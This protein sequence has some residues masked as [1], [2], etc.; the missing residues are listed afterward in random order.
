MLKTSLVD[1]MRQKCSE[2]TLQS[3]PK[4]HFGTFVKM[5]MEANPGCLKTFRE[6]DTDEER[7]MFCSLLNNVN[8]MVVKPVYKQKNA[9]L[10]NKKRSEGNE[11][12][13][14]KRYKQAAMLYTVSVMKAEAGQ[15][16]LAYSVANRSAC[17]YYLGDPAR[18]LADTDLALSL[19]YPDQ[20]RCSTQTGCTALPCS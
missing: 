20:V 14:A 17:L 2:V 7:V 11:A 9:E 15:E 4:G 19:G 1:T 6:L 13:Q 10:A 5:I 16:T 12:F 18:C 8:H 3:E